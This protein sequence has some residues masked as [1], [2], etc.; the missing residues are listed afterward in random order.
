MMK[1]KIVPLLFWQVSQK[2]MKRMTGLPNPEKTF[3]FNAPAG[4]CSVAAV[5]DNPIEPGISA[6]RGRNA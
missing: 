2:K 3:I 1:S 4:I 6:L 5:A